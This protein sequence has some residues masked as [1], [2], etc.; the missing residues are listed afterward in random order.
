MNH[1][2]KHP[3]LL[4]AET[5]DP[6]TPLRNGRRLL[7]EMGQNARLIVHHGYGHASGSDRSSCTDSISQAYLL[8]GTVPDSQETD[9]YA[10]EKPYTL[11]VAEDPVAAWEEHL[12]LL[13]TWQPLLLQ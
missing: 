1:S 9:C 6:A 11:A 13:R 4:I 2:L 3:V 5:Y 10:D 8:N 12:A 7:A